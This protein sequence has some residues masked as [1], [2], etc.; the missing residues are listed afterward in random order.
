[1][2]SSSSS[3]S[4]TTAFVPRRPKRSGAP[5]F[6]PLKVV[7]DESMARQLVEAES[8]IDASQVLDPV[9]DESAMY[10]VTTMR[11]YGDFARAW[12]WTPDHT[13]SVCGEQPRGFQFNMSPQ[14]PVY[15]DPFSRRAMFNGLMAVPVLDA[16]ALSLR[17]FADPRNRVAENMLAQL[18]N[19]ADLGG[20]GDDTNFAGI[21]SSTTRDARSEHTTFWLATQSHSLEL[22]DRTAAKI[23]ESEPD[24][25]DLVCERSRELIDATNAVLFE[26][27]EREFCGVTG[28]SSIASPARH[29]GAFTTVDALF[30][31]SNEMVT[32]RTAQR[33]H[34]ARVLAKLM[35]AASIDSPRLGSGESALDETVRRI[36]KH[37]NLVEVTFND[38]D[39]VDKSDVYSDVVYTTMASVYNV[40]SN[41]LLM[42]DSPPLGLDILRGP[43]RVEEVAE[44][45]R[46]AKR[47]FI[48]VPTNTGMRASNALRYETAPIEVAKRVS[49]KSVT[50]G[51]TWLWTPPASGDAHF[52]LDA[53]NTRSRN[54]DPRWLKFELACGFRKTNEVQHL[55][56]VCIRLATPEH[57]QDHIKRF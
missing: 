46:N 57:R 18:A 24:N 53:E 35:R 50:S 45:Q 4:T 28:S 40:T 3:R 16:P 27:Y 5:D 17:H 22:A 30:F 42:R 19:D 44:T 15:A 7:C 6:T 55:S 48:S 29:S 41:G 39:R 10:A 12:L 13:D 14:S 43:W 38:V 54:A 52:M 25:A 56:N 32:W 34:R 11:Q 1:M 49:S 9:G 20:P 26:D 2:S 8:K 47:P 21:F 51:D 36:L 31:R 33:E 37:P 23:V